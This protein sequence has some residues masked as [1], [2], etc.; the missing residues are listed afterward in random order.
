MG[1][2]Y[3]KEKNYSY[4]IYMYVRRKV[5]LSVWIRMFVELSWSACTSLEVSLQRLEHRIFVQIFLT[6][7]VQQISLSLGSYFFSI[8]LDMWFSLIK[9]LQIWFSFLFTIGYF[10]FSLQIVILRIKNHQTYENLSLKS[11]NLSKILI[12]QFWYVWRFLI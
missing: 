8:S 6:V 4:L 7:S 12:R 9:S 1:E 10:W 3:D 11:R 5:Y 2:C